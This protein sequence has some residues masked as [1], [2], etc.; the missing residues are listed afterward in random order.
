ML[1]VLYYLAT[2]FDRFWFHNLEFHRLTTLKYAELGYPRAMDLPGKI[3]WFLETQST[4]STVA[5]GVLLVAS[6]GLAVLY[7]GQTQSAGQAK[8]DPEP[9]PAVLGILAATVCLTVA[10]VFAMTPVWPQYLALPVPYLLLLIAALRSSARPIGRLWLTALALVCFL[11]CVRPMAM[12]QR[13]CD[14]LDPENWIASQVQR[15]AANIRRILESKQ[16]SG[17]VATLQPLWAIEAGLPIYEEFATGPFV[18]A[19]GDR[20]SS[21]QRERVV[22]ISPNYL[23]ERFEKEPPAAILTGFYGPRDILWEEMALTRYARLRGYTPIR[24]GCGGKRAI[25]FLRP[26]FFPE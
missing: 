22:A 9:A 15:G 26:R 2:D 1:P 3:E 5:L 16:L 6:L 4:A 11:A 10:A 23:E 17:R 20:L 18:F 13:T 7:R 19:V 21:Q 8:R 14:A 12:I 25:L 24:V